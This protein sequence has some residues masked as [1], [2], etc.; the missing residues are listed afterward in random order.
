MHYPNKR[1]RPSRR[2]HPDIYRWWRRR[3]TLCRINKMEDPAHTQI[4]FQWIIGPYTIIH[5]ICNDHNMYTAIVTGQSVRDGKASPKLMNCSF[6]WDRETP[7]VKFSCKSIDYS[8]SN[9]TDKQ[10]YNQ[11]EQKHSLPGGSDTGRIMLWNVKRVV[12]ITW[13]KN[14]PGMTYNAVQCS[15]WIVSLQMQ[16]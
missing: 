7:L 12:K 3:D 16:T 11:H 15:V 6:N 13:H 9:L 1:T 4:M 14:I 8:L 10:I 5:F 2:P